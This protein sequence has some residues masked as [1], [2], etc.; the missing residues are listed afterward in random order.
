MINIPIRAIIVED[1]QNNRENLQKLLAKYC[2][3]MEI[4]GLCTSALEGRQ[5]IV[6]LRPDLVFLDIEMPGGDGF[7]MLESLCIFD[8]EVIFVTA[9]TSYA[10]KAIKFSALDYIVK[11]IDIMELLKAVDKA[12]EKIHKKQQNS[13]M[14]NLL[15][16]RNR[17]G[18]KKVIALPLSD[19]IEF[20]E[21]ANIIHCQADGNY[22]FF[23]LKDGVKLLISKTLK[24]Y[25]ELLSPLNFLR[26]HQSH[27]INL[28]EVKSFVKTDGGYIQMKDGTSITIS[29]QRREM[30]L[31]ILHKND[32]KVR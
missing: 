20:V 30:V 18:N 22:T 31:R 16:N 25:D 4:I 8:F 11:P 17:E 28:D 19:K 10:I 5:K 15:D 27:L 12:K 21:I 2:S 6:E 23:H 24:E 3:S 14:H 7:S 13:R 32:F 29:R 26:V 9:F 1:E